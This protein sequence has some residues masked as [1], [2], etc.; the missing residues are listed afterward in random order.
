MSDTTIDA[1]MAKNLDWIKQHYAK[2]LQSQPSTPTD[3]RMMR[4]A[5]LLLIDMRVPGVPDIITKRLHNASREE[6]LIWTISIF[7]PGGVMKL[8]EKIVNEPRR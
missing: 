4:D 3:T 8:C 6:L 2:R 7:K 1:Q 5:L